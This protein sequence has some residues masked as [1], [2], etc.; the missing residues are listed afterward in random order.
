MKN[1]F[2][3]ITGSVLKLT[4]PVTVLLACQHIKAQSAYFG[5][6]TVKNQIIGPCGDTIVPHGINYAPYSWGYDSTQLLLD[7]VAQTGANMVRMT[8]YANNPAPYYTD[9]LLDSAIGKCIQYKMIPVIELHDNTCLDNDD[10]LISLA[11]W[12]ITPARLAIIQ[13]YSSSLI[14]DIANEALY[15]NWSSAPVAQ[16]QQLYINTYDTIISL[17]RNNDIYVP[18]MIDAPDCGT[19]I[20]V[21]SNVAKQIIA[22]DTMRNIIFSA[23]AYWY[24]Y[25]N[26]DSLTMQQRIDTAVAGNF[27]LIIGE[28][29]NYQDEGNGEYCSYALNYPALLHICTAANI[30]WMAWSWNNDDCASRQLSNDGN[31]NNLSPWGADFVNDTSYGLHTVSKPDEYLANGQIPC[32]Q[33]SGIRPI[34]NNIKPYIIYTEN[35][36]TY[37]KSLSPLNLS[38]LVSDILG[39]EIFSAV[40]PSA[41]IQQLPGNMNVNLVRI[42]DGEQVW[43]EKYLGE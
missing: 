26:N 18:L 31:Y 2:K 43:G 34:Q 19:S 37:F 38:I 24:A 28:M 27:P 29:A 6:Q 39:R 33:P 10:S 5:I 14:I 35:G 20:D 30:G 21:F 7:Q 32:I 16:A 40:I 23:H 8:W 9:A 15:V 41:K 3:Q 11:H 1:L 42:S 12:Y 25:A 17:L 13:K 22:A 36:H 4:L